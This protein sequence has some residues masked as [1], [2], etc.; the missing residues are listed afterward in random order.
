MEQIITMSLTEA[1]LWPI[2]YKT[3]AGKKKKRKKKGIL[4]IIS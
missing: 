1:S 3:L 2:F 4:V